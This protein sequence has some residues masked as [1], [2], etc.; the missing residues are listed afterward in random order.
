MSAAFLFVLGSYVA[1]RRVRKNAGLAATLIPSVVLLIS[2]GIAWATFGSLRWS[3]L[4]FLGG[5]VPTATWVGSAG[6]RRLAYSALVPGAPIEELSARI[7][8]F[9]H[10]G[11]GDF[12]A[13]DGSRVSDDARK[14][15]TQL[16]YLAREMM[17]N[18]GEPERYESIREVLAKSAAT[19]SEL[20]LPETS[21]LCDLGHE[22]VFAVAPLKVMESAAADIM[23]ALDS[24]LDGGTQD[25]ES[26][27]KHLKAIQDGRRRL[28]DAAEEVRDAV[29]GN[30][31]CSINSALGDVLEL[32][33]QFLTEHRVAVETSLSI[34]ETADAVRGSRYVLFSILENL[35]TNAVRSMNE[36]AEKN[37]SVSAWSD[38]RVCH[39][40]VSDSGTGMNEEELGMVF[41]ERDDASSG[42][43][44]LPY[45][46]RTLRKLGGDITVRSEPGR[47]TTVRVTVSHWSP[48]TTGGTDGKTS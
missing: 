36:S 25:E 23:R 44:G 17:H 42:G 12:T 40:E 47:G 48:E 5:I 37:L 16:A 33:Q 13:R 2:A 3:G 22:M 10:G 45:S 21:C 30:P 39:V 34:P 35:L 11:Q 41:A 18:L 26:F 38:G 27:A 14:N 32:R 31:G 8:G 24:I 7:M 20:V 46:K 15:I 4:L 43:F 6:W 1:F 29:L 19:F 28:V 9:I